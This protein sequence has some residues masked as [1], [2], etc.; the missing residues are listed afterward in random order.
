[1]VGE[2]FLSLVHNAGFTDDFVWFYNP[3]ILIKMT[4]YLLG[5]FSIYRRD[6]KIPKAENIITFFN[7]PFG[8]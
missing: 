3:R 6:G 1:M 5:L 2:C 8:W 7:F 4:Q